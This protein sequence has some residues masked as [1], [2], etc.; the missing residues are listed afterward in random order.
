MVHASAAGPPVI[1]I[2][3]LVA[4]NAHAELVRDG[5]GAS[6][7]S[8]QLHAAFTRWGF[9]QLTGT[10]IPAALNDRLRESLEAL[11]ALPESDKAALSVAHNGAAWRGYMHHGG[12]ST[13]GKTDEVRGLSLNR[14]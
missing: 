1:D 3:A 6:E 13:H 9:C 10:G 2:S 4:A 8:Q 14:R 11:F 12:E 5:S 7:A